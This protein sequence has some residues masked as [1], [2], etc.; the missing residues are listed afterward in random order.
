MTDLHSFDKDAEYLGLRSGCHIASA[1][2]LM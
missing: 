2:I 1:N